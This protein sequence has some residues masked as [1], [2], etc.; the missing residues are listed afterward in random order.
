MINVMR[1]NYD[2]SHRSLLVTDLA[3]ACRTGTSAQITEKFVEAA[4]FM[5]SVAVGGKGKGKKIV[6]EVKREGEPLWDKDQ[7]EAKQ[8]FSQTAYWTVRSIEGNQV[9]VQNSYGMQMDVSKDMLEKMWSANHFEKEVAMTMTEL[10]E[11]MENLGDT[12]FSVQFRK[13]PKETDIANRLK[14]LSLT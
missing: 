11:L 7:F 8:W 5:L 2:K 13:K 9:R 6:K 12:V 4:S 3:E 1:S 10:A 14:E